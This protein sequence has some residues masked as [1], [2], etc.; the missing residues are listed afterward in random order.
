MHQSLRRV[1]VHAFILAWSSRRGVSGLACTPSLYVATFH[2]VYDV[3]WLTHSQL[4]SVDADM[5]MEIQRNS[6]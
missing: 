3:W 1:S 5:S 2:C 4:T 6:A